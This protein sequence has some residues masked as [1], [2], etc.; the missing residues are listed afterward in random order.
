VVPARGPSTTT[1]VC[2]TAIDHS[3]EEAVDGVG[4]LALAVGRVGSPCVD[5][6]GR[7]PEVVCEL[8]PQWRSR[9]HC[10]EPCAHHHGRQP[11]GKH[12]QKASRALF[13]Q[14]CCFEGVTVIV[15]NAAAHVVVVVVVAA[16]AVAAIVT[17][18]CDSDSGGG[19]WW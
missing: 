10:V 18:G 12:K 6:H 13:V 3:V 7:A 11:P 5:V 14:G 17:V 1:A 4:E 2:R 19:G 9:A 16:V 8:T 15:D